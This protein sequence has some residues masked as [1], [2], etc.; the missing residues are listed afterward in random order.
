VGFEVSGFWVLGFGVWGL[1]FGVEDSLGLTVQ[2]SRS[3]VQGLG[4]GVDHLCASHFAS[5]FGTGVP[6]L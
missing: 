6:R 1:G 3:R 4:F 2:D 5:H